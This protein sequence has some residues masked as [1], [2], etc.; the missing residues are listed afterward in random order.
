MRYFA[1]GVRSSIH[2]IALLHAAA[3]CQRVVIRGATTRTV[4]R[5]PGDDAGAF[6]QRIVGADADRIDAAHAIAGDAPMLAVLFRGDR[7]RPTGSAV[8]TLFQQRTRRTLEAG[9]LPV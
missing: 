1:S 6:L 4:Q 8:Y 9:D 3:R 2:D 7:D 5:Q